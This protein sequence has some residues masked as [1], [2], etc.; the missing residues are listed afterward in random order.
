MTLK[1]LQSISQ[2]EQPERRRVKSF[3]LLGKRQIRSTCLSPFLVLLNDKVFSVWSLLN[4]MLGSSQCRVSPFTWQRHTRQIYSS[5]CVKHVKKITR[6]RTPAG[7]QTL[8][9]VQSP[10]LP[11]ECRRN[12][13]HSKGQLPAPGRCCRHVWCCRGNNR[14]SDAL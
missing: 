7:A 1:P 14:R 5:E 6:G 3:L 8:S 12:D 10:L 11:E 13:P 4:K 2:R 9:Q